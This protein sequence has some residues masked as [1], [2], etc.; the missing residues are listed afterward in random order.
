MAGPIGAD[1]P[2]GLGAR[3]CGPDNLTSIHRPG[4]PETPS[5]VTSW[6]GRA[7]ITQIGALR[8]ATATG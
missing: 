4:G 7:Q 8:S 6:L 5:S 1:H 3:A 2:A